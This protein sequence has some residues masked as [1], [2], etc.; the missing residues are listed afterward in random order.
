MLA[1]GGKRTMV[2]PSSNVAEKLTVQ[3]GC[4]TFRR[5]SIHSIVDGS[6]DEMRVLGDACWEVRRGPG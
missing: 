2:V 4:I 1:G 5:L 3:T 6:C